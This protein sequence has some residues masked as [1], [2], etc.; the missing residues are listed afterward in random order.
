MSSDPGKDAIGLSDFMGAALRSGSLRRPLGHVLSD[1]RDLVDIIR[2]L[3]P[4]KAASTVAGLLLRPELQSNC[5]RLEAL[6]HFMVA[7]SEG[8]RKPNAK[9]VSRAFVRLDDTIFGRWEDP[10]EDVFV[11]LVCNS[12][13]NFRVLEGIWESSA[14]HLQR[15]LNVVEGMPQG[16]GYAGLRDSIVALLR[17]SDALAER[18]RLDRYCVGETIPAKRIHKNLLGRLSSLRQ[19]VSFTSDD[20][21]ALNISP[22]AL[23]P[24]SS[25]LKAAL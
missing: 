17:L 2:D 11:S 20:L 13:G 12:E 21:N 15:V 7:I 10:A 22:K 14:F 19:S 23:E 24:F 1:R 3:D 9:H 25:C 16:G 18:Q 4:I 5:L 8:R 6:I